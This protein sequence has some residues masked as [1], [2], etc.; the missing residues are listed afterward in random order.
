MLKRWFAL[1]MAVC[2]VIPAAAGTVYGDSKAGGDKIV[3]ML[4]DGTPLLEDGSIWVTYSSNPLTQ[5]A[6]PVNGNL[7]AIAGSGMSGNGIN[8]N[9]ELVKWGKSGL[10]IV[11][12]TSSVKQV[13]DGYWLSS[14]GTVWSLE[15]SKPA[16]VKGFSGVSVFDEFNGIIGGVTSS[17][18]VL[19][20]NGK[21]RAEPVVLG[22]VPD[23]ASIVKFEVS[24]DY[25]AIL[26]NDGRVILF[27]T[28]IVNG[29]KTYI[30]QTLVT[31]GV[32]ISLGKED[33]LVF[34][35]KDGTVWSARTDVFT[36]KFDT[37]RLSG[38]E[39]IDKVVAISGSKLF[40]ARQQNG[41][42]VKYDNGQLYKVEIPQIDRITLKVSNSKPKVGDSITPKLEFQY[43]DGK[44]AAIPEGVVQLSTDK[45]HLL[46]PLDNGKIKVQG[47]GEA[48]LSVNVGGLKQSVT[49]V[50]GLG[51]PIENAKQEKGITYLPL[52]P[53][54]QALGGT[55]QY[56]AASKTF[57]IKV[58]TIDI[59]VISG[60]KKAKINDKTITMKAAPIQHKGETLVSSDLL[61]AALGAKLKWNAAKQEMNVS[62]GAAQFVV[63]AEQK[64]AQESK[65][66][67]SSSKMYEVPATG[68]MAG[69]KVL[70]GHKYEKSLRIYFQYKNGNLATKTEDIRKVNLNQKVTWT[71]DY[72]LK[73]TN[74]IREIYH[75][76]SYTNEFTAEWLLKKF[77]KLYED[78]LASTLVD[79]AGIVEEYLIETGQMKP[80]GSNVTLTPEA[81]FE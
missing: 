72:G 30:L 13:G 36:Q 68:S 37:V 56:E 7:K 80:Y 71:D 41:T 32:D 44:K 35:K 66:S 27:S 21:Y 65:P 38:I 20:Y 17:G 10:Q 23:T 55:V 18:S 8:N 77:G 42:W 74:T 63:K 50:S 2:L 61:T 46:H 47:V 33:K 64:K 12:G 5:I 6:V 67:K 31:D 81:E 34:A 48:S 15:N 28:M 54:F 3:T 73:R 69:W 59:R 52:K 9:G 40:Y 4:P 58:G 39:G 51:K 62:L 57:N 26:Y 22:Q 76:F 1:L 43:A 24:E 78:W 70:K 60:S 45:P 11:P 14:D 16:A 25:A 19:H 75:L 53:V 49:I 29:S 79:T